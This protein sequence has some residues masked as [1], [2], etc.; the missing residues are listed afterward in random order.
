MS[1]NCCKEDDL[2]VGMAYELSNDK[3]IV[4]TFADELEHKKVIKRWT[5][6]SVERDQIGTDKSK[7]KAPYVKKKELRGLF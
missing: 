6:Y 4:V 5:D 7:P 3:L 1:V 2:H